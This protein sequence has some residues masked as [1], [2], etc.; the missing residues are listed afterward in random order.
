MTA[1]YVGRPRAKV[2]QT[3][4][5]RLLDQYFYFAMS[6]LIAAVVVA[7]FS[8]TVDQRLFHPA[9]TPPSVLW[10]HGVVF[11]AW[12][13]FFILQSGL[14]RM[15]K[16]RWHRTLGW[17]GVALGA[18]VLI[19]GVTTTIVMHRFQYFQLHRETAIRSISIPLWDM[20][21]FAGT[22]G[23]AI[24][25]RKKPE[26]HRRLLLVATCALTAAAFGRL[27]HSLLGPRGFYAGVDVLILLGV[28]RDLIVTRSVHRVY[29][30]ALPAFI[31]GQTFVALSLTTVWW[32]RIAKGILL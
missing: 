20:V 14:V 32:Y 28:A 1:T 27:P 13:L 24:A 8:R 19:L 31:A 26:Y 6:V 4:P 23:L 7:G 16:V 17:F 5:V 21:C 29:L 9:V 15:R 25:W 12:V 22:F 18:A 30:V 10:V 11:S 2:N 3:L